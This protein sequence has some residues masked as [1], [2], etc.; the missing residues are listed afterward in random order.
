MRRSADSGDAGLD[1]A[2]EP[3][4][5]GG[6]SSDAGGGVD[7]APAIPPQP[8]MPASRVVVAPVTDDDA[9][10]SFSRGYLDHGGRAEW[11]PRF[12]HIIGTCEASSWVGYYGPYWTRAQFSSDTWVKVRAYLQRSGLDGDPDDAYQV[13]AGVAWWSSLTDPSTQWP[14]CWH[15]Y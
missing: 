8:D 12:I 7:A 1:N 2:G 13:G 9:W 10:E 14:Y 3:L 6:V 4:L 11:L 5:Q 15:Q